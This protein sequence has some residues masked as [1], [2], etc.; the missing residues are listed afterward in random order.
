MPV[1]VTPQAAGSAAASA[2]APDSKATGIEKGV[3]GASIAPPSTLALERLSQGPS[4]YET[5]RIA[6]VA[7]APGNI[8][9]TAGRPAPR[10]L[11]VER[12]AHTV[13]RAPAYPG[14]IKDEILDRELG[15]RFLMLRNCR[16]D[17]A[18][19]RRIA[20]AAVTASRLTLRWT[21]EPNG[22]VSD[23]LVVATSAADGKIMDCVKRQMSQ[24][25]FSFPDGGPVRVERPFRF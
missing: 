18:R 11:R 17:V 10:E 5:G 9:Q 21:I 14:T 8:R 16:T 2:K 20:P 25:R 12:R 4:M 6:D 3:T 19:A 1:S 22:T 7:V 15:P 24:W 23:T 13:E